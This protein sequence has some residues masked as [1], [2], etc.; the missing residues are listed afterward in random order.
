MTGG[1]RRAGTCKS[2]GSCPCL[3]WSTP[4]GTISG[5]TVRRSS[6]RGPRGLPGADG[7]R[8]V[9]TAW[10]PAVQ[11]AVTALALRTGS[12]DTVMDARPAC[13]GHCGHRPSGRPH[14][15]HLHR[16]PVASEWTPA[17]SWTPDRTAARTPAVTWCPPRPRG[18]TGG[19]WLQEGVAGPAAAGGMPPP[20]GGPLHPAGKPGPQLPTN[21]RHRGPLECA[22]LLE[23]HALRLEPLNV[24]MP[25][26]S[27]HRMGNGAGSTPTA[28]Q[29]SRGQARL[30]S[31]QAAGRTVAV[32]QAG[33]APGSAPRLAT[34]PAW[35]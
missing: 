15:G 18:T 4:H 14:S 23:R 35:R 25:P 31:G 28:A 17:T 33:R 7:G 16:T 34:A 19:G 3:A 13:G 5:L 6:E 32:A 22:G 1:G 9:R 24:A 8:T 30:A 26:A 20:P 27:D 29:V 10:R 21:D 11:C 2:P 12:A